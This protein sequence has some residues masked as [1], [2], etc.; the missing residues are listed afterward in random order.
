MSRAP[1]LAPLTAA[2]RVDASS[3]AFF[4][5]QG[6]THLIILKYGHND[7]RVSLINGVSTGVLAVFDGLQKHGNVYARVSG[8]VPI[9]DDDVPIV[10]H[11]VRP[12]D[13]TAQGGNL[14]SRLGI[15]PHAVVFCRHGGGD[16]FNVAFAQQAVA[17]TAAARPDI[18]FVFVNTDHFI[19]TVDDT[20]GPSAGSGEG[21]EWPLTVRRGAGL[22]NV[23]FL[24]ATADASA[25]ARFVDTCDAMVHA[26]SRGETF[27]LAVAEFSVAGRPVLTWNG[28]EVKER[29]HLA[30]LGPRGLFYEDKAAL[31]DLLARLGHHKRRALA[32]AAE[33]AAR[34][35]GEVEFWGGA[36]NVPPPARQR[37]RP[38]SRPRRRARR[39]CGTLTRCSRRMSS[40]AHFTAFFS[41]P[42]A[43]LRQSA[44]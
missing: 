9:A 27:G 37:R 12:H 18:A 1:P 22:P 26:R 33:V 42:R 15:A 16:Q 25:K 44:R 13:S 39:P 20:M 17:E 30:L 31:L 23:I 43:T 3:C 19:A 5:C 4:S 32:A 8:T 29:A 21:S 40:C 6:V 2:C 24:E 38:W 10:P 28:S 36:G 41:S 11:V 7:G 35:G 34:S 14:R